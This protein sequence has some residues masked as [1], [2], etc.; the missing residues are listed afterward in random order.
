MDARQGQ[1]QTSWQSMHV[2][3][4]RRKKLAFHSN[5]IK[6]TL[7]ASIVPQRNMLLINSWDL[8]HS[9]FFCEF[10]FAD[11][12]KVISQNLNEWRQRQNYSI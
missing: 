7:R 10:A 12:F 5:H 2:S 9:F 4:C 11:S 8:L 1:S 6:H 3:K